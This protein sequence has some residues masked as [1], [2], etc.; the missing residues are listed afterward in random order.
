MGGDERKRGRK[1]G[2]IKKSQKERFGETRRRD[3]REKSVG[4]CVC[5]HRGEQSECGV[6]VRP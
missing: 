4:K 5:E 3:D 6:H 1:T 2:A